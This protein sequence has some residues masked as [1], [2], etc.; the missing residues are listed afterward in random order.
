MHT[1]PEHVGRKRP[2]PPALPCRACTGLSPA[3]LYRQG[4]AANPA[5]S[6]ATLTVEQQFAF[7]PLVG[8]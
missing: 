1:P 7:E 4:C 6:L 8:G 2:F 3:E 5:A